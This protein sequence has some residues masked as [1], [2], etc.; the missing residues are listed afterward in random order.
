MRVYREETTNTKNP[1]IYA[2]T[3]ARF[4]L[5]SA[6]SNSPH[7]ERYNERL[8]CWSLSSTQQSLLSSRDR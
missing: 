1:R 4:P 8:S 2:I 5:K 7:C 3:N 6:T